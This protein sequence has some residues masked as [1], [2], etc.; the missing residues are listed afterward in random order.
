LIG[1]GLT[2]KE[3]TPRTQ[4]VLEI[5]PNYK[6]PIKPHFQQIIGKPI[7]EQKT[8]EIAFQS[9]EIDFTAV[10]PENG[11]AIAALSDAAVNEI[12]AIDY[13]WFGPNIEKAPFDNIKV[14]QAIRLATDID[15]LSKLSEGSWDDVAVIGSRA[16][17]F[18]T[19]STKVS[20]MTGRSTIGRL[21]SLLTVDPADAGPLP[22]GNLGPRPAIRGPA[23]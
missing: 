2:S 4:F 11:K 10:D 8:A 19:D 6:G 18:F 7:G 14:R 15:V 23:C 17:R 12:P 9:G 20:V 13:V 21:P 5:N 1:S 22:G 16:R 3:W